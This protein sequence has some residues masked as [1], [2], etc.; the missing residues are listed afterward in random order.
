MITCLPLSAR[1]ERRLGSL[2]LPCLLGCLMTATSVWAEDDI[3][4]ALAQTAADM[5]PYTESFKAEDKSVQFEM[6]PIPAGAVMMGSPDDEEDREDDEG[7]QAEIKIEPFWMA[8]FEVTWDMYD[9]FMDEY[10]LHFSQSS[11]FV[12]TTNPALDAISF[13]TPLYEPGFTFELGHEPREPAVTMTYFAARQFT[14]WIS[15]KTGRIYRLPT[16]AEWEYACRAGSKTA[17]SF[18]DDPADLEDYGWYYDNA[19]DKYQ[20]VGQ[21]KP[22][23]W[24]LYDM[25]GNVAEWVQDRYDPEYYAQLAAK[26]PLTAAAA[27]NWPD[28][29]YPGVVRGGSWYDDAE[30]LRSAARLA[31]DAEWSRQDPQIPNSIWWHTDS[32]YVGFRV[33]RPLKQPS[34]EELKRYWEPS[35]GMICDILD[36]GD[37]QMR[38][39]LPQAKPIA[40]WT[41]EGE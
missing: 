20:E 15:L 1:A 9:R 38:V 39:K 30:D 29:F 18:G 28:D 34:R 24:G 32:R 31:S 37:R 19:D 7:P 41:A 13:P 23:A 5:K 40:N 3:P 33:I 25:H 12:K 10:N 6:V 17:Y 22:N 27:V 2:C 36:I 26:A 21:K 14:K 4:D 35:H 16:E 8:K 11:G